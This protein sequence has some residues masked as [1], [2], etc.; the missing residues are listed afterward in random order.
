MIRMQIQQAYS[1]YTAAECKVAAFVLSA[2]QETTGMT[3]AELARRAGVSPSAVIRFCK[4]LKL[5]GFSELKILLARELGG[6]HEEVELPA[7][8]QS[9]G[10]QGVV[11][12][13]FHSG[14][15]TLKNTVDMLDYEKLEQMAAALAGAQRIFLF[16]VGTSSVVAAD[17]QYRLAQYGLS[18]TCCT[19]ILFMNVA[20]VNLREGDVALAISHSGRTKAVVDAMRRAH[21]AGARTL[22]ITSFSLSPLFQESDIALSVFAD[23]V[24]Y[25]VE[26]VSARLAHVCLLDSLAMVLATQYFD[27]FAD[28]IAAR[29]IILREIRYESERGLSVGQ[30]SD[31]D[32]H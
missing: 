30:K 22:A 31:S 6:S 14:M 21:R 24:N 15:Q 28:H 12:K 32:L 27:R 16:G 26:A 19:D 11:K 4:T 1:Q 20:A 5:S 7:F 17:A 3:A 10:M 13:V 2:P 9:D 8:E 23:E 25:P 29:N 18:V